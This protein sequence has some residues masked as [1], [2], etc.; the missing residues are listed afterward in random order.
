MSG[1]IHI[2]GAGVA[3][4]YLHRP[5]L[6]SERFI[7]SPFVAG[8]RLYRTGDLGRYLADGTIE[9]LGRNDHQ[10]K[11][12]GFRIE[13]GEIEARLSSYPGVGEAVVVA[14]EEAGEKRLVAYYTQAGDGAG[15][16]VDGLR[17]HLCSVLPDYMVPAAY[18]R[19]DALPLTPNGKLDR[20]A[21]P[22]PEGDAY[23]RGGYEAPVGEIEQALA[24][25]WGEVL[26]HERVGRHDNF[27]ELGGHSLLA[28]R[29]LDRM[30]QAGLHAQVRDLFG[31]P[32]VSSLALSVSGAQAVEV[33][34]NGIVAGC[35]AIEPWMLP[36]VSLTAEEIGRIVGSVPGGAGN[37]Q[38][39]YPLA[40]LQEGI[41]FHHLSAVEGDPYLLHTVLGIDSR[42]G[43][44]VLLRA[45][46]AVIDRH[47]ILRTAVAWEGLS[48]PVQV[49]WRQAPLAV[50]QVEFDRAGGDVAGQLR[51]RADARRYRLDVRTAPLLRVLVAQDEAK[52]RW[53]VLVLHHHLALDHVGLEIVQAEMQAHALGRFAELPAPVPFRNFVGQARLGVSA[54]EHEAYFRAELGDVEEATLPFGLAQVQGD[55]RGIAEAHQ[56]IEGSLS[57]RVRTRARALGVSAASLLHLAWAQV[58]GRTSGRDDVVFGTV[59]LGRLQG[60]AGSDRALGMF[61][62]TLPVR[63]RLGD[64][65]VEAVARRTHASLSGLVTHEHAALALAQRCSAVPAPLP[66][67]SALLNYR[68]TAAG[69][70][71]MAQAEAAWAGIENLG[72]EERTNYPLTLSVDDFGDGFALTVQA[73]S[74]IDAALV[75]GYVHRALESVIEALEHDPSRPLRHLEMLGAAERQRQLVEWNATDA[76]Y[77]REQCI[78]ELF[79]AQVERT[80]DAI[81]VVHEDREL[82]YGELNAR[83]NRLAHHLRG[84]GVGPD[85]RV[86][87]CLERSA[88]MVVGLL[89]VLKAGGAYVPLD[90]SYPAERLDYML[91]DSAPVVVLTQSGLRGV[92]GDGAA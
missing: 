43:V 59:L 15:V 28:V 72:G 16:E 12:R 23:A 37:V 66:L 34:A 49:V 75:C 46:Q 33:P 38:D 10:V 69:P 8:E 76:Q 91:S 79:E 61:I 39:I 60:M 68:H 19:L 74:G 51:A 77:P 35:E 5:E 82:S 32:T 9:Y 86:A 3:R 31:G 67:F 41:L 85:D 92:L 90:P 78:H 83:A 22:A 64:G 71:V 42:A 45:L 29:L 47:D 44:E 88:E 55:G 65:G 70:A 52:G 6:T 36:L 21:L 2:G 53:V 25:I 81:A 18:V 13:L 57:A 11:I 1:E 87:I 89:A 58:V 40:P 48:Q 30:R 62:N 80:P 20:Q 63:V 27:F 14:R 26:G 50:E 54:A 24:S 4:G 84:L 73:V 7:A 56:R 17:G